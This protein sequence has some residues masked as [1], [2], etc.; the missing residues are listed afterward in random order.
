MVWG[1]EMV[2]YGMEVRAKTAYVSEVKNKVGRAIKT[3]LWVFT[4]VWSKLEII[5]GHSEDEDAQ[6]RF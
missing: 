1:E 3:P 4:T 2:F 5:L 6:R